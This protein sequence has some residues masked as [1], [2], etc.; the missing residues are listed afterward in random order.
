MYRVLWEIF[1]TLRAGEVAGTGQVPY[2]PRGWVWTD[3]C[4]GGD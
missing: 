1:S 4:N 3:S 2:D